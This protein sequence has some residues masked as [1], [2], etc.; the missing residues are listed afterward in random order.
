VRQGGTVVAVIE[1]TPATVLV[2]KSR[3]D[4]GIDCS[5]AGYYAGA[6]VLEPQFQERTLGNAVLGGEIGAIVDLSTGA[7]NEYPHW[8]K[9]LMRP[10]SP[11][12]ETARLSEAEIRHRMAVRNED[13][14]LRQ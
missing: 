12:S 2:G 8:V 11:R 7:V 3:H 1:S 10:L 14:Y 4:I 6:A 13:V 5:R 9:I